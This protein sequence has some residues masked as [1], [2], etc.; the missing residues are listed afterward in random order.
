M[1]VGICGLV[2]GTDPEMLHGKPVI[3]I[4]GPYEMIIVDICFI[5]KS[6]R[7]FN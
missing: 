1:S 7:K 2:Q 4:R 3:G 6:L 5:R